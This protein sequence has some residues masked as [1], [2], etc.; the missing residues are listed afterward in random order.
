MGNS[1]EK[2][3]ISDVVVALCQTDEELVNHRM[4]LV[5]AKNRD[6]LPGR[7]IEVYVDLDK[8]LFT[9]LVFA[10]ANGWIQ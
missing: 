4:R 10:K 2:V 7:E 9:D 8:M 5:F 6:N 3:K 1:Y